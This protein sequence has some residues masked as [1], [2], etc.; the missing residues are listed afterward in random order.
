MQRKNQR[1]WHFIV[2]E[3]AE[4]EE[5]IAMKD[6]ELYKQTNEMQ[7]RDSKHTIDEFSHLL[8]WRDDGF[9]SILDIG[10]ASA[11]I[12]MDFLLPILP[13]NFKC[14]VGV[15]LSDEMVEF[16]RKQ[17]SHP[18]VSF[19]KFDIGI[20]IDKQSFQHEPFDHITSFYCLNRVEDQECAVRNMYKLLKPGGD[21]L[22][23]FFG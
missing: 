2:V 11:D 18:K 12:M 19:E 9:D 5:L 17:Y 7:R 10:F 6:V 22:L 4:I 8:R 23:A 14:L 1:F 16:A 20:D 15:E 21:I 13:K 3:R